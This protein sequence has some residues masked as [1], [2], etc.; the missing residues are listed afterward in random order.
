MSSGFVLSFGTCASAA[1]FAVALHRLLE[2]DKLPKTSSPTSSFS[3]SSSVAPAEL[4]K[5]VRI[6][7][8]AGPPSIVDA[9]PASGRAMYAGPVMNRAARI[10]S[11][12]SEGGQVLTT[13][14]VWATACTAD[15]DQ[16][17]RLRDVENVSLTNPASDMAEGGPATAP[18][19]VWFASLGWFMLKGVRRPMHVVAVRDRVLASTPPVVSSVRR[20]EV[21]PHTAEMLQQ[22][23]LMYVTGRSRAQDDEVD[24]A[25]GGDAGS[26][27]GVDEV[28][29]DGGDEGSRSRRAQLDRQ[30]SRYLT[31]ARKLQAERKRLLELE[32]RP[33]LGD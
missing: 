33:S 26:D 15:G 31:E 2:S 11:L 4:R 28:D 1:E 18:D 25:D 27:G 19:S 21:A 24:E 17:G 3:S 8:Y 7:I 29:V 6:G 30:I 22:N 20:T 9:H 23:E 16:T 14:T 12:A 5:H 10:A 32:R 13:R